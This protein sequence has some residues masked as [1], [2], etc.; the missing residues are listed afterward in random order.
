MSL[1]ATWSN[2]L[3]NNFKLNRIWSYDLPTSFGAEF[4]SYFF[5]WINHFSTRWKKN[6]KTKDRLG[7][8]KKYNSKLICGKKYHNFIILH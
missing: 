5:R 8:I 6:H 7:Y 3:I 4:Y 1:V 2:L